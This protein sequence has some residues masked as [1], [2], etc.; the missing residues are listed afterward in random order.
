M[1]IT[2]PLSMPSKPAARS[3]IL[4]KSP[5]VGVSQSPVSKEMQIYDWRASEW[6]LQ[7]TLPTMRNA[8]AAPWEAFFSKLNGQANTFLCGDPWKAV[9]R[10]LASAG[11]GSP[12]VAAAASAGAQTLEVSGLT[13][14]ITGFLLEADHVQIESGADAHLHEQMLD[15]DTDGSGDAT[16]T[17][18]PRLRKDYV[19]GETL[20]FMSPQGVF[21]LAVN[22]M[23]VTRSPGLLS[24]ITFQAHED[25]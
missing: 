15:L 5:V 23:D 3:I 9:P 7:I 16:L 2:Y 22:D 13:P 21:R 24:D 8:T 19:G 10:G 6:W 17:L 1:T 14:S 11:E 18:W 25:Q 4:R 12:V 20:T